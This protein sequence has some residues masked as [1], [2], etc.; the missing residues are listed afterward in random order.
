MAFGAQALRP[1]P[2]HVKPEARRARSGPRR[3]RASRTCR[4]ERPPRVSRT[5]ARQHDLETCAAVAHDFGGDAMPG[6]CVVAPRPG[7][8]A[9]DGAWVILF[10][11]RR[12]GSATELVVL[13]ASRFASPPVARVRLPCRVPLGLHGEW[14]PD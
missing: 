10:V 8:D 6:E 5:I 7:S 4:A 14:L 13:D 1:G 3:L 11:H 9:E 2:Q 12:D